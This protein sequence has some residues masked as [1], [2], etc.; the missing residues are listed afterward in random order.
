MSL[1]EFYVEFK[2]KGTNSYGLYF[3]YHDHWG[4]RFTCSACGQVFDGI[5]VC[6]NKILHTSDCAIHNEPSLPKGECD[7]GAIDRA[8]KLYKESK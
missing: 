5:S 8:I 4:V 7:C 1:D 2:R 3:P 6:P